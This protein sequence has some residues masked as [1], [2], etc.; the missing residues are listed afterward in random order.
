MFDKYRD[1][2][3][4]DAVIDHDEQIYGA[5]EVLCTDVGVR[6]QL[7]SEC[8]HLLVDEFQDLTPAQLLMLRLL[9][10]PAYDVFGV[11]DDD[12]VI[13]GYAGAD[14]KFLID[15]DRYFP[16]AAHLQLEVNYRCPAVIVHA[17]T[18]LLGYNRVRVPKEI[19]AAK[20][21]G[22]PAVAAERYP[23]RAAAGRGA[24]ADPGVDRRRPAARCDRGAGP[25]AVRSAGRAAA[26]CRGGDPRQRADRDR[27]ARP[28]RD[29]RRA[30]VSAAGIGL[31]RRRAAGSRSR[32]RGAPS[33][34]I[35]APRGAAADRGP[36]ALVTQRVAHAREL[37]QRPA[38]RVRR[39][40]G[41]PR[42]RGGCGI[43]HRDRVASRP[44][45]H[46]PRWRARDPRS[47]WSRTRGQPSRRSQRAARGR[48][49]C[50]RPGRVRTVA[51]VA[52]RP[53]AR[54][55]DARRGH[56]VDGAPGQGHGVAARRHPRRPRRSHAAPPR[57]RHG[58]GA[59][60][61][62]RRARHAP[63][64]PCSCSRRRERRRGSS[65]S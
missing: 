3:R 57:R 65:K 40:P 28:H 4:A 38:R 18:N 5:I 41:H 55:L 59:P 47:R 26:L 2:L 36:Q 1:R 64:R 34:P 8:R 19:R 6:R 27:G 45:R 30:R 37:E 16:G 56:L 48:V 24:G 62:P 10:A 35:A 13:Y 21:A 15:Y 42:C 43:R 52:S 22:D 31:R 51:A 29:A 54:R 17:A 23:G 49:A 60:H 7:Q 39:R 46:R 9:A 12:Q 63:T 32:A 33:E 50:T 44:R 11:G 14:P 20:P 58:G 53:R 61:L 25:G